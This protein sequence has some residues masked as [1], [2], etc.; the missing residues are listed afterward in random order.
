[1][2]HVLALLAATSVEPIVSTAWLQ[3]H[4][5]DPQVRVVYVGDADTYIKGHIPGARAIEHME[6][7]QMGANG[8]R[9]APTDIL[10]KAFARAGVADGSHVVLYGDTPMATGWV[11]RA[12]V[13]IGHGGDVSWLDGG[14]AAWRSENRPL[15]MTAP[16]PG[17]GPL[18]AKPAPALF[19]DAAW[20]REHLNSPATKILDVRTPQEWNTGHLPNATLVLWQ[21]LY[22]D[23]KAQ[24]LKSPEEIRALLVKAGVGPG[25]EVVTYCAVG[26]RASLMGWAAQ[27]AGLPAKIYIGSWQDWQRD[28]GNP[29][30][31]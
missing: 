30:V 13:A 8:H 6:T 19:V 12:L 29:I 24:K 7:V 22:A 27:A 18:T 23:V 3:A 11:N 14:I 1:M 2:L 21:D 31:R 10:V 9:M 25:Q 4:L 26:M 15:E 28:S 16:S 17:S 5:A 20:V